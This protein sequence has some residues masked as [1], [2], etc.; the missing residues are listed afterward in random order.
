[1]ASTSIR[2]AAAEQLQTLAR[3]HAT[4][5]DDNIVQ[6]IYPG[7]E[8]GPD[9]M[10]IPADGITGEIT[11]ANMKAG[12]KERDDRFEISYLARAQGY[13]TATEAAERVEELCAVLEDVLADDPT[14]DDLDGL[15]H[16]VL[17]TKEGP[18]VFNFAGGGFIAYGRV[19]ISL[20]ARY[21]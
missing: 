12:R 10:W 13:T 18:A 9:A 15:V 6:L 17:A 21:E 7:D 5:T 11:V 16:A 1:M 19:A 4:I 8:A 20:H 14:L 3:A 2:W